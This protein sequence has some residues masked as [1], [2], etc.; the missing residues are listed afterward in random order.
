MSFLILHLFIAYIEEMFL[1]FLASE[2][3]IEVY[4]SICYQPTFFITFGVSP[5][6]FVCLLFLLLHKPC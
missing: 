1:P 5:L 2:V 4:G 3:E 6:V